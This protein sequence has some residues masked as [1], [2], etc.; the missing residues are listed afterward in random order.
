MKITINLDLD[1]EQHPEKLPQVLR[2]LVDI[3]ES[4]AEP[5][6][7]VMDGSVNLYDADGNDVGC[8][9]FEWE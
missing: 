8:L 3:L 4:D 9:E 6:V 5:E 2:K 7:N 1:L